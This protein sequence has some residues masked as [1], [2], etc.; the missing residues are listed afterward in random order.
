[1]SEARS[2][3]T[4]DWFNRDGRYGVIKDPEGTEYFVYFTNVRGQRDLSP[5]MHV[6]FLSRWRTKGMRG[7][8]AYDVE[9]DGIGP[10][11]SATTRGTSPARRGDST[12]STGPTGGLENAGTQR[13]AQEALR[14]KIARR[15]GIV[16]P[17]TEQYP[18]GTRVYHERWGF[19]RVVLAA[20][21][22]VSVRLEDDPHR[23][24]DVLRSEVQPAPDD[25]IQRNV[26]DYRLVPPGPQ[27]SWRTSSLAVFGTMSS[28]APRCP[29]SPSKR[30]SGY[31]ICP[32]LGRTTI[33]GNPF[34]T[35][36]D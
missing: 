34:C 24:E 2:T 26:R 21:E 15:Q 35:S 29:G 32:P 25:E 33:T 16:P 11:P 10:R 12:R 27:C 22:T 6:S 7:R 14:L 5:G 23:V 20:T 9:I 8:E 1:M 28:A 30:T 13:V 19:G 31:G 17:P 36:Q 4:V 18:P 3:G